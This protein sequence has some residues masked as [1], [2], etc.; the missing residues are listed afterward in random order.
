MSDKRQQPY[1]PL[2]DRELE[3]L[4]LI[5]DGLT[6]QQIADQLFLSL[7]T[8]K[9]HNKQSFQ[10]LHVGSRMQAVARAREIDVLAP[11]SGPRLSSR[12]R[13][14][15]PAQVTPLV[16][17]GRELDK[18][19]TL[20]TDAASRLITILAP[21]GMG[22][23][24]LALAV[25]ERLLDDFT[26]GV[27]F[28]PLAPLS[29][30]D[31]IVTTIAENMGLSFYGNQLPRDQ[32]ID[33]LR[34]RNM[35]LVLDNFEHL[36][37]GTPLVD[38]IIQARPQVKLLTT[39]RERLNL[40]AETIYALRGLDFPTWKTPED[41]PE[42]D[43]IKLFM[44]SARRVRPDFELQP[45]D[46]DYLARIC[47]LTAGM[48]LGI[49]L[50][51]GWVD[52]LSL[53]QI[54]AEIQQGID[55]L[56]TDIRDMPERHRSIRATFERTWSRLTADER[57]IFGRLSVLRG[58]FTVE[59]AQAVAG[60]DLRQL[61]KLVDK[62]LVEVLPT[63]RYDI[64]AL[65]RQYAAEKL[66]ECEQFEKTA[67]GHGVYF[68]EFLKH[69]EADIKGRR[70]LGALQEIETDFE[71]VRS[72]WQ[73]ATANDRKA[74]LR[75]ALRTL[76]I[77][78][79]CGRRIKDIYDLFRGIVE[80][81]L[82]DGDILRC[83]AL[84]R[85]CHLLKTY[86]QD[87]AANEGCVTSLPTHH[88]P[89]ERAYHLRVLAAACGS[90]RQEKSQAVRLLEE[91]VALYKT[92]GDSYGVAIALRELA[93]WLTAAGY[94]EKSHETVEQSYA[95][96]RQ[97]GAR[98]I[99]A[100]QAAYLAVIAADRFGQ[101]DEAKRLYTEAI[102]IFRDM[103]ANF[104]LADPLANIGFWVYLLANGDLEAARGYA[105]QAFQIAT[106]T[107]NTEAEILSTLVSGM[108]AGIEQDYLRARE[109]LETGR[110]LA[111]GEAYRTLMADY[112]LALVHYGL[113]QVDTA[114]R[115]VNNVLSFFLSGFRCVCITISACI[116][117]SEGKLESAAELLAFVS[118]SRNSPK[119]WMQQWSEVDRVRSKLET[120]LGSE[121]YQ[122]AWEHGKT[123]D[124]ETVVND[125]LTAYSDEIT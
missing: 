32:L 40:R 11:A 30:P 63:G 16:G 36:L 68:I 20:L 81:A 9:W 54:A 98:N 65:L 84:S 106:D 2:T 57:T 94:N 18:L 27:F 71:N 52:I 34:D 8:V 113:G 50:A 125:L 64:H 100:V 115:Y 51:A 110:A 87:M 42:Y 88:Q 114:K 46:L 61:R 97:I 62:A 92:E 45:G 58:G 49:E 29:S 39:S 43:A 55:I 85:S 23:T 122:A 117:A 91:A 103:N 12:T 111:E 59:A 118:E 74:E 119:G 123:L 6:N 99:Q 76:E 93:Y 78:G 13:H 14:N 112:G 66:C 79:E 96:S 28:V 124:L 1:E 4:R 104:H 102:E 19:A 44:Q 105:N 48:P 26:H 21:G 72:A 22:K 3:I 37:D 75:S 15:L 83:Q 7:E 90:V 70:Q 47:R 116:Q 120:E 80:S 95:L 25:A 73:W 109:L 77:F 10:K 41:T 24:R 67:E 101:F 89:L 121:A 31:N 5:A 56:E 107:H 82:P 38:D 53:E 108:I 86:S 60:A 69:R 17:R 35:L 33:Y